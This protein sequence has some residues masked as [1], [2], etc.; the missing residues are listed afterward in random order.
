M[1]QVKDG[2][3]EITADD[4][5]SF[6]YESGTVYNPDDETAGLFRGFLL[7]RVSRHSDVS[8]NLIRMSGLPSYFHWA[9]VCHESKGARKK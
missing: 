8:C 2:T 3:I 1:S 6:L 5:L 7:V 4:V 9:F